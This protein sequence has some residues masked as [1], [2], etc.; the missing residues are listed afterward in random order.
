LAPPPKYSASDCTSSE[1]SM[2]A[3]R[4][5]AWIAAAYSGSS[6]VRCVVIVNLM[7]FWPAAWSSLRASVTFCRRCLIEGAVDGYRD[8]NG[9][10]FPSVPDPTSSFLIRSGRLSASAIAR[11]VLGSLNG[12][13]S[14]RRQN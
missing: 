4:P 3:A 6:S 12:S 2:P 5:A 14:T 7:F 1:M 8:Q 13:R 9:E 10:S 11:R